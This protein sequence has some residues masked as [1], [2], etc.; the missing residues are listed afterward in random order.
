MDLLNKMSKL[1]QGE[2][3]HVENYYSRDKILHQKSFSLSFHF[4]DLITIKHRLPVGSIL[5]SYTHVWRERKRSCG[6]DIKGKTSSNYDNCN[7]D[8]KNIYEL[9]EQTI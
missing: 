9:H 5:S 7:Q 6:K 8:N 1:K 2:I 3:T 4:L